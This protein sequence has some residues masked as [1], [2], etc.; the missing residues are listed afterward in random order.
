[1]NWWLEPQAL[2]LIALVGALAI[3]GL[4]D[5]VGYVI[6]N[7]I[8]L[9]VAGLFL[10]FAAVTT[11]EVTWWKH[12]AAAVAV[13]AAGCLLFHYGLMGGGDVKLWAA[14]A[15]WA[16]TDL[17]AIHLLYVTVI[18]VT[19]ALTLTFVRAALARGLALIPRGK[20]LSLP[21]VLRRREPVPY[22]I[23]IAAGS[24]LLL[25]QVALGTA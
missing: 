23:A 15:L 8:V 1:M 12:I 13:F 11:H 3:A 4:S 5:A 18:G 20:G 10:V 25:C 22:G 21:R 24:I 2:L 19:V 17:L 7:V 9:A 14:C 16:G 6:P